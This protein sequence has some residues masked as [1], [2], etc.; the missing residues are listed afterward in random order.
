MTE[1]P[2]PDDSDTSFSKTVMIYSNALTHVEFGYFDFEEQQWSHFSK[3]PFLLKCW[4]YIPSPKEFIKNKDWP[5][6]ALKGYKKNYFN[7]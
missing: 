1:I 5:T 7:E 3:T 2:L 6:V 4:C